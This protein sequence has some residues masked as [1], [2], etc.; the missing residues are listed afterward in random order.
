MKDVPGHVCEVN[1]DCSRIVEIWNNVFIQY[2]R[3][4]PTN[5]QPLPK[6]HV[7]TAWALNESFQL[8]RA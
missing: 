5:F 1:G 8:S 6:R 4:S 3:T 7:D 2:N